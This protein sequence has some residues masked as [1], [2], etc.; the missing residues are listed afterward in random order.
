M[1]NLTAKTSTKKGY[2]AIRNELLSG[3]AGNDLASGL[4]AIFKKV[5]SDYPGVE[6]IAC[7]SNSCVPQ[8]ETPIFRSVKIQP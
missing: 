7:W 5:I 8:T 4:I 2:C 6:H 3:R 1:Y